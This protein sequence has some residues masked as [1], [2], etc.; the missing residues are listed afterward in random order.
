MSVENTHLLWTGV[1]SLDLNGSGLEKTLEWN[2]MILLS[3]VVLAILAEEP[4]KDGKQQEKNDS[5]QYNQLD[6]CLWLRNQVIHTYETINMR[7][8]RHF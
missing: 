5:I 8:K 6:L 4:I 1:G 7:K 2:S 3:K